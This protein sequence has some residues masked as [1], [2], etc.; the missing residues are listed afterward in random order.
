MSPTKEHIAVVG[1]GSW[2]TALAGCLARRGLPVRLWAY[3]PEVAAAINEQHEN[4]VFLSGF[5]LPES[6]TATND[7][8]EALHGA[9]LVLSVVPSHVVRSVW[10]SLEP[11]L[12]ADAVLVS[13]SKGI[14]GGTCQLMNAVLDDVIP[15]LGAARFACLSGPSFARE[16]IQD[17]PCAVV[18]AS[19][20]EDTA[21]RVQVCMSGPTFRIYTTDDVV[22]TEMGGALKNVVAIAVGASDGLEL[23]LNAR[24]ALITRGLAEIT[25]VAVAAGANPLTLAGLA[26]VGDLVLTCTGALSRNR[27]V[28]EELGKG[29]SLGEI[30][31]GMRMVAE[32]VRTTRSAKELNRRLGVEMPITD[33][34]HRML[35]EDLPPAEATAG[36][37]SR[38]LK[39]EREF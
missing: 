15:D 32:G 34:V 8:A 2:G 38:S 18:V 12:P 19:A 25:R 24:A 17:K 35:Y 31:E 36:L 9:T 28:G 30:L 10:T 22:G 39:S 3:E 6:L 13:A 23:G 33:Q 26:G 16:V 11:H 21:R 7:G 1:A 27:F 29:R 14:E 4:P 37:L 5:R 20:D